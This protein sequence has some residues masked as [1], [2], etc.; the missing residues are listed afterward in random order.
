M[1][2]VKTRETHNAQIKEISRQITTYFASN[3][4]KRLRFDHGST[5]QLKRRES[6]EYFSVD[7]SHLN[8]IIEIN[9]D[10]QYVIVEPNVPLDRLLSYTLQAGLV[11]PVVPELPGITCGGAVIGGAGESSS[12]KAGVFDDNCFEYEI[13]LGNGTVIT[14]SAT[15]NSD[16]F[17]A[18][19][20]SYGT[21]GLLSLIK[22]KLVTARPY[23]HLTYC[24]FETYDE[25]IAFL[26][27][28]SQQGEHTFLD[29]IV[30]SSTKTVVML[31][32]FSDTTS[33]PVQ[34][35]SR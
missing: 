26:K 15:Q 5:V 23:V 2:L 8:D 29:G 6:E 7:I 14:A 12:Y 27:Q 3:R 13:V 20:W 28:V 17:Y 25:A 1:H 19:P 22:M 33:D 34:T 11:P 21:L 31:G 4:Q 35:F 32:D 10:E 9:E 18:L 30:Y 24:A 16:L